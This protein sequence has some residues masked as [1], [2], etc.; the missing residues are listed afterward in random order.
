MKAEEDRAKAGQPSVVRINYGAVGAASMPPHSGATDKAVQY[1]LEVS[2]VR[3]NGVPRV[4][5]RPLNAK[6]VPGRCRIEIPGDAKLLE[7]VLGAIRAAAGDANA[8]QTDNA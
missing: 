2:S 3:D 8:R 5:L 4:V 6:G 7:W 1:G